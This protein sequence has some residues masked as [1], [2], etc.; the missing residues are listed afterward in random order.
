MSACVWGRVG[1]RAGLLRELRKYR[2]FVLLPLPPQEW[3][4]RSF[5]NNSSFVLP[6][7]PI[8]PCSSLFL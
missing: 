2:P 5:Q 1:G 6:Y 7:C 4:H 8:V 3:C